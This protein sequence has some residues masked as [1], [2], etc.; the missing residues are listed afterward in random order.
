MRELADNLVD[1]GQARKKRYSL[2]RRLSA[3]LAILTDQTTY[4]KAWKGFVD[5]VANLGERRFDIV[6]TAS[7]EGD[8]R[9]RKELENRLKENIG[10]REEPTPI[11][12]DHPPAV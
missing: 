8:S 11:K 6:G 5:I 9:R 3:A 2:R 10:H 4:P 12:T 7:Y 1:L